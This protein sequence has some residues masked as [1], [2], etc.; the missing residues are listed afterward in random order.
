MS[1]K[2]W[3][4][5]IAEAFGD[6]GIEATDEQI[7]EVAE[8]VQGASENYGT[9]TGLDVIP[10]PAETQAKRELEELKQ[11]QK[12][13]ERWELETDPCPSCITTGTVRDGW[14]RNV[15]CDRCGGAGRVPR[16]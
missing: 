9:A 2:Y 3:L 15:T 11:K 8:W 4:E 7:R 5:C 1:D 6:V 14:D 10:N 12:A 16:R 13:K